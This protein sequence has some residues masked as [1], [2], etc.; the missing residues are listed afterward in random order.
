VSGAVKWMKSWVL[1]PD[2]ELRTRTIEKVEEK[3]MGGKRTLGR[4]P[5]THIG[6][7]D[8]STFTSL[9]SHH[10]LISPSTDISSPFV[11]HTLEILAHHGMKVF[12]YVGTAEWFYDSAIRFTR[13]AEKAGIEVVY[14]EERGGYHVEGCVMPPDLGGPAARLQSRLIQFLCHGT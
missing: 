14:A 11:K 3:A 6:W 5:K 12:M 1:R 4:I 7:I 8:E 13:E 2:K 10:P 9:S